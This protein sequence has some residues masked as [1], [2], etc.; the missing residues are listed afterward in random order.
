MYLC[1]AMPLRAGGIYIYIYITLFICYPGFQVKYKCMNLLL[2][3]VFLDPRHLYTYQGQ[4]ILLE[5]Y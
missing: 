4:D 2:C 5:K 3:L 1:T